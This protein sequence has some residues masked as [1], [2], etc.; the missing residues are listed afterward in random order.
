MDTYCISSLISAC[1]YHDLIFYHM[2]FSIL[3]NLNVP[4][5]FLCSR[6]MLKAAWQQTSPVVLNHELRKPERQAD[7]HFRSRFRKIF[8]A[9][10]PSTQKGHCKNVCSTAMRRT[11]VYALCTRVRLRAEILANKNCFKLQTH[12]SM[13]FSKAVAVGILEPLPST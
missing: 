9:A 13:G 11:H 10:E 1:N 7:F 3:T 5:N 4:Q 12:L 2:E 8:C 6:K